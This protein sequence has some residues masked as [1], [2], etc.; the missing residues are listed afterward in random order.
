MART[1][2]DARKRG[3]VPSQVA[4]KRPR[5]L[6]LDYEP[7]CA[8]SGKVKFKD[9]A[10]A[11]LRARVLMAAGVAAGLR[12]YRCGGCGCWHMSHKKGG[13]S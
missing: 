3:L 9:A 6:L 12:C 11:M 1:Y 10:A 7:R 5:R 13:G 4:A 2:K 8:T